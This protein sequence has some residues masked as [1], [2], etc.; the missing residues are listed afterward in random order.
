MFSFYK[1]NIDPFDNSNCDL[2]FECKLK[3]EHTYKISRKL[4]KHSSFYTNLNLSEIDKRCL[5]FFNLSR[6]S[7]CLIFCFYINSL[8]ACWEKKLKN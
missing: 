1:T 2:L 8:L 3:T 4:T 7:T 6:K 5:V